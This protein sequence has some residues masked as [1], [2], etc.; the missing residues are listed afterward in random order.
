MILRSILVFALVSISGSASA[1]PAANRIAALAPPIAFYVARGAANSCG[2]GCD[3]WIVAD[4]QIDSAAA[5]RLRA[6]LQRNKALNLPIYFSSPGGNLDQALAMGAM[7]REK[8]FVARVAR[9]VVQECGFE[10]QDSATCFK[11]K[12]SGREL[13][14][15]LWTRGAMCNSACPYLILG[16]ATREIAPDAV[17]G[18]HSPKVILHINVSAPTPTQEMRAAATVKGLDRADHIIAAYL[19]KMG[20]A[21]GLLDL[22]KSVPFESMHVLTREEIVRFGIDRRESVETP[23]IFEYLGRSSAHK[24]AV[25]KSDVQ[26]NDAQKNNAAKNTPENS[27]RFLQWRLI[28]LNAEQF[29]LDLQRPATAA[30]RLA[31]ISMSLGGV[32]PFY[33]IFIPSKMGEPE[34]WGVRLNRASVQSLASLPQFEMIETAFASDERRIVHSEKVSTEGLAGALA[35]LSATCSAPTGSVPNDTVKYVMPGMPLPGMP[36]QTGVPRAGVAK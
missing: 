32:R 21:G 3:R 8:P 35:S 26:S 11:L 34:S 20:A 2:P 10:A 22:A 15:E 14:G 17:L 23:W 6:F 13:H 33:F 7:L 25:R 36:M 28:C 9:T 16:A 24:S 27:Y 1:A 31:T 30:P 12:Q 19:A 18:V 5:Q 4:G 29:E